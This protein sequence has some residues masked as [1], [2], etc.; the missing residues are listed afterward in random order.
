MLPSINYLR[1]LSRG[2]IFQRPFSFPIRM[3]SGQGPGLP[4][5]QTLLALTP[6]VKLNKEQV[7]QIKPHQIHK[8]MENKIINGSA[9]LVINLK[10]SYGSFIYDSLTDKKFL[11]MFGYYASCPISHNHPKLT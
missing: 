9:P 5:K 3:Y 10:K 7:D 11:D 4:V 6:P 8:L 1:T 2:S